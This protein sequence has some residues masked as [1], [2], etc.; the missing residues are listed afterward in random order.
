MSQCTCGVVGN[1]KAAWETAQHWPSHNPNRASAAYEFSN[2]LANNG[3][4]GGGSAGAGA[5]GA[6]IAE[7]NDLANMTSEA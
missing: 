7:G 2:P 6:A 1:S 5:A 4:A 3:G